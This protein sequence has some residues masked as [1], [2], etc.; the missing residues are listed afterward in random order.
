[1]CLLMSVYG[2]LVSLA[3]IFDANETSYKEIDMPMP[4]Y[5]ISEEFSELNDYRTFECAP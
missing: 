4:S 1:M 2:H 5:V 3:D